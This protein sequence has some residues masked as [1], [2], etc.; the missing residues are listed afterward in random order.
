MHASVC[1]FGKKIIYCRKYM[2][3]QINFLISL[4]VTFMCEAFTCVKPL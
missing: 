1:C 3:M 2:R 4:G